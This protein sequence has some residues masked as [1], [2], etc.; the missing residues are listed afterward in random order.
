MSGPL[1]FCLKSP[2][3][4]REGIVM[5]FAGVVLAAWIGLSNLCGAA[6]PETGTMEEFRPAAI[7][8]AKGVAKVLKARG[9][10]SITVGSFTGP[11]NLAT[12]IGPGLRQLVVDEL[13]KAGVT[14]EKLGTALALGG[15]YRFVKT[16]E[17]SS[18]EVQIEVSLTDDSGQTITDLASA[19]TVKDGESSP[20]TPFV[21]LVVDNKGKVKIDSTSSPETTAVAMGLTIDGDEIFRRQKAGGE[22]AELIDIVDE[23]QKRST[24]FVANGNE[25][26]ASLSSPYGIQILVNGQPREMVIEN[27]RPF[28]S[29]EKGD[30]FR[31][32]IKNDAR[33]TVSA[34]LTLDGINSFAFST[35]RKPDGKPKYSQWIVA[36]G[37]A[38]EVAGWH[39]DN[40][41]VREFK[42]TDSSQSAAAL[43]G[44]E[45]SIGAITVLIRATWTTSE[46]PPSDEPQ[47][48]ATKGI[49][50][51]DE[52]EQ[53]VQEDVN[54]RE[55]GRMRSILTIR[56]DKPEADAQP[57]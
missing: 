5:K 55:F 37:K 54:P 44:A 36:P 48:L 18:K 27:G 10:Q 56:Y 29:L 8:I 1:R 7:V 35:V 32:A 52:T 19:V 4:G 49:G 6:F 51:G 28:V 25:L 23:G 47:T 21:P 16:S 41:K 57:Q 9:E 11:A 45:G 33:V 43:T 2:F 20:D 40:T 50:F 15:V 12:A 53:N 13:K 39:T 26:R 17:F 46:T 38:A 31:V 3:F 34:V 42:V 22:A 24:A 30:T 14:V